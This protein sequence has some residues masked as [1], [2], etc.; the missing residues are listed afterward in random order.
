MPPSSQSK[1]FKP[2]RGRPRN[3]DIARRIVQVAQ[4]FFARRGFDDVAMDEIAR[5]AG[6]SKSTIYFYFRDKQE[7]FKAAVDDLLLQLPPAADLTP[8]GS[9][10]SISEHLLVVAKRIN[11]LLSSLSFELVRRTLASEI[12]APLRERIWKTAG[13]P[14]FEAINDYLA[15]QADRGALSLKDTRSAA[16]LFIALIAGGKALH[17]QLSGSS[18]G[19][20]EEDHLREAV[21]LFVKG[22]AAQPDQEMRA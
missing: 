9:D 2:A 4:L 16:S 10:A 8:A 1:A 17:S 11:Q 13:L 20:I 14:Y 3:P 6:T 12:T 18:F 5:Q 7:L 15:A 22:H 21:A 19:F